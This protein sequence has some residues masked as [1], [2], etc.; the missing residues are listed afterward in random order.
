MYFVIKSK[1]DKG[2]AFKKNILKNVLPRG[3]DAKIEIIQGKYRQVIEEKAAT[4]ALLNDDLNN[5]EYENVGLQGE[6]RS[7]DQQIIALRK[8]YVGYLSDEDKNNGIS[9]I[10]KNNDKAEY[11]YI[12]ICGQ[13]GYK[14]HKAR[15]LL[16]GNTG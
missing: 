13:H 8:R 1:K 11:P 15:V 2:K 5:W 14:R 6:I 16:T 9:I 4:I 3:F 10:A 7:K 12:S